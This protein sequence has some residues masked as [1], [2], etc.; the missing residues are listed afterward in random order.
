MGPEPDGAPDLEQHPGPRLAHQPAPTS[1]RPGSAVT[2]ESGGGDADVPPHGDRRPDQG[3]GPGR[4]G[5]RQDPGRLRLRERRRASGIGTDNVEIAALA[6][7]PA[8]E[9]RRGHRDWTDETMTNA[10]PTLRW[11]TPWS[12]RPTASRA[13]NFDFPHNYNQT[14]RNAV[15]AFL[16]KWLLGVDDPASTREGEL[17]VE[18]PEDLFTFDAGT[19]APP[20]PRRPRSSKPTWS[21]CSAASSTGSPRRPSPRP[22]R[23]PATACST[24]LKVRVGLEPEPPRARPRKEV[25]KV[26]RDGLTIAH[27]RR[28]P[29]RRP[30]TR[31]PSSG[32]TPAHPTGRL[33]VVFA[34]AGQGRPGRARRA[35]RSPIV[36]ALLDRGQSVIGFDPLF[37]GESHRPRRAGRAPARRRSTSRPTTR[38]SPPTRRRTWPR[39]SPGRGRCPTSAR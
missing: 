25:R 12:A 29:R 18:K 35:S 21:A 15:Y 34:A 13:D 17:K 36:Q 38:P 37:V 22:G 19:P 2:G 28:R 3:L 14:S 9:D 5:L 23:P 27:S 24:A 30:A 33:T 11:S 8:D 26:A 32:S 1:T 39:S 16:G 20:T 7:P 6:G 31:S 10:F 4:D